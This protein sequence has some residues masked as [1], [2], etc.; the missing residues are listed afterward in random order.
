MCASNPLLV[1]VL[2]QTTVTV[3]LTSAALNSPLAAAPLSKL[4][5]VLFPPC[6]S[7]ISQLSLP[8]GALCGYWYPWYSSRGVTIAMS[9]AS[10][11]R[12]SKSN[13]KTRYACAEWR[14]L[15]L[16][17][18][19][20]GICTVEVCFEIRV[21]IRSWTEPLRCVQ[22]E[23]SGGCRY[24]FVYDVTFNQWGAWNRWEA[25]HPVHQVD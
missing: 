22:K 8:S 23:N 13:A 15:V 9:A 16:G 18:P 20:V 7:N 11:C 4:E 24:V 3:Y 1:T 21:P 6:W 19:V 5:S 25:L 2:A 12:T 14:L 10:S 17:T